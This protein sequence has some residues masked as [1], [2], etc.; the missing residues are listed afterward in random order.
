M[1]EVEFSYKQNNIII[2]CQL[3]SKI[4]DIY[5]AFISK[6][7]IDINSVYFI[8]SGNKINNN[9]LIIDQIININDRSI[10][11]MKIL[12]ESINEINQEKSLIKS[13]DIICPN[14]KEKARIN[15]KDYKIN[16]YGCKNNHI[17]KNILINQF[18]KFQEIDYFSEIICQKCDQ[19]NRYNTYN[20]EFYYCNKCK[21]NLCPICK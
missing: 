4:I 8:Y 21:I 1:V 6:V 20:N 17:T 15:I 11:K 14:C 18:N 13:N 7:G 5:K 19:N 9:E 12:V 3:N 2:Q 16:I 10:N